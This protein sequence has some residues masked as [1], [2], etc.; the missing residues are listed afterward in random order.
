MAQDNKNN[1]YGLK[2]LSGSDYEIA[3][4]Q[5]D[6]RGWD[7]KDENGKQ[8]G[9][10]E[11]L[12]FDENAR[13]VRYMVVDLEDNDFDLDDREV[14]LPIGM[15]QLHK[16]DDDVL[17]PGVTAAQL[18]S[19][20]DYDD[21]SL[22]GD[23]EDKV[24]GVF[25]VGGATAGTAALSSTRGD[26]YYN[27]DYFNE[28]NLYRNRRGTSNTS[29]TNTSIPVIQEEIEVGKK[30]VETGG[31]RLRSRIVENQVQEDITLREEKV[32]VNRTPVDRPATSADLR[33]DTL[34]ATERAEVP[35]V[36][37]EARV[38]EEIS[39]NKD[40]NERDEVIRDTVR[41]TEVDVD[42]LEGDTTKRST[43][44]DRS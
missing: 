23:L 8:I 11:E 19:L 5:P 21:D 35:I 16:D 2:K 37:K 24:R 6:I 18:S 42:K 15:A 26:D 13:K 14:L 22:S 36:N 31:I 17:L 33:E 32:S 28:D 27:H 20:P 3:E 38:V 7:V 40:V 44:L 30:T 1:Q 4:G 9:E 25:G 34:E 43:D 12:I 10:V 39:L 29:D 41:S